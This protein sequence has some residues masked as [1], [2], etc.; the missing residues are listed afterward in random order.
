MEKEKDLFSKCFSNIPKFRE[1]TLG[2]TLGNRERGNLNTFIPNTE[3]ESSSDSRVISI[4]EPI[5]K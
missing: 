2:I 3:E 1:S 5:K 4:R